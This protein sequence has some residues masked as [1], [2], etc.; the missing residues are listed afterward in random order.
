MQQ[1]APTATLTSI[2]AETRASLPALL[3]RARELER[4]AH[5]APTPPAWSV[6]AD[7]PEV[8]V[9][10]EVKRRSPSVGDIAPGLDPARLATAY[11][12]GGARAISVLTEGR[13]FGG[14]LND[15]AR[16]RQAVGLPVLRK[17]F[18][19]HPVQ[20]YE[21]RAAG[22]SAV[23]VI[24]RAVAPGE[25]AALIG[26]ADAVGLM[27][28]VEVHDAREL[29]RAV[30][31]GA[32]T[33]GV[34]SRDLETFR[35]DVK[36]AAGVLQSVPAGIVAV[37]ESGIADRAGVEQAAHWGADAVLVGTAVASASDPAARVRDLTGVKRQRA[38]RGRGAA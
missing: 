2:L 4:A 14:S 26:L 21:S 22:A 3:S 9:I 7:A 33:I 5:T 27:A 6:V 37:A 19:L 29:E 15:L 17:D 35:V 12:A 1:R 10:A 11:A 38:A 34:N 18:V 23:L 8:S 28:L 25:L 36:A 30:A 13:H 24:V 16:V 32:K 31:A 20:V